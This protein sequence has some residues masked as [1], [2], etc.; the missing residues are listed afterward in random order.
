MSVSYKNKSKIYR[1]LDIIYF[2]NNSRNPRYILTNKIP[3]NDSKILEIAVGTAENI[4]LLAKLKPKNHIIGIDLSEDML[5]IAR[6]NILKEKIQNIE[7]I[8]MDGMNIK[9]DSKTF[10]FIIISLLLHEISE[11]IANKILDECIKILKPNGKL[12]VLE[13]EEPKKIIQKIIFLIIKLFEPKEYK[14]FMKKDLN[15]YF[16]NNDFTINDIEYGNYSKVIELEK[17]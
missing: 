17:S 4:I 9:F 15:K 6:N 13:W 12:Y 5:E 3:N 11:N 2:K 8:K 16:L 1:L 7:L 10:D 14:M